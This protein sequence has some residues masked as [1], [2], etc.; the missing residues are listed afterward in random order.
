MNAETALQREA[1]AFSARLAATLN[2]VLGTVNAV[3]VTVVDGRVSVRPADPDGIPLLAE[4]DEEIFLRLKFRFSCS[5]DG[6]RKYLAV[7]DSEFHVLSEWDDDPLF[8]YEFVKEPQGDIPVAH[9]QVHAHRDA[10]AYAMGYPGSGSRRAR[11]RLKGTDKVPHLSSLHF[12]L[13]GARFRPALE[14]VLQMLIEEFGVQAS[15]G[16]RTVVEDGREEWR[17]LQLKSAVRDD[18]ETAASVLRDNGYEVR[19]QE[20]VP[21]G[22]GH[23]LRRY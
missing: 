9:L 23:G 2:G 17:L 8:R 16:W 19:P 15:E 3:R 10:I 4:V 20:I 7:R 13:G 14:D 5:W 18:L 11:R 6:H 12:P 21:A 22:R 1:E